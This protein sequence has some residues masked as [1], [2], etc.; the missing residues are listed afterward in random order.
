MNV[1][2]PGPN[3]IDAAAVRQPIL[4]A[5]RPD[6]EGRD[7]SELGKAFRSFVGQTLFGEMLKTMR[8]TVDENPYFHGGRGE[9]IF[10]QQL[11]QVLAEKISDAC[12]ERFSQPMFE[13]FN[14]Q[15]I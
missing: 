14:L 15:R 13:L 2:F 7:E 12:S 5:P 11:D 8:K 6:R 10:R 4:E 9:K 3:P 1:S